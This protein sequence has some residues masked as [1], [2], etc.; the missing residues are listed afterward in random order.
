MK[1]ILIRLGDWGSLQQD[2]QQVRKAVFVEEQGIP[3]ELEWDSNDVNCLHAVAYDGDGLPVGTGR[4]LPDG[5]I[6]RMAVLARARGAGVGAEILRQLMGQAKLRGDAVVV[7][8]AQQ[9]AE[10]FYSREGFTRS[11]DLF[12]EA[13][14]P[15]VTMKKTL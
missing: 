13:G 8:N 11:G 15:H 12:E 14:I 1:N 2:A 9:T 6:G 3:A 10:P 5:H 7:L 4:L